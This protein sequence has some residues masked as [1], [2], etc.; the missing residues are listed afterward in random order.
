MPPKGQA[1]AQTK[2]GC[3][4]PWHPR[5]LNHKSSGGKRGTGPQDAFGETR[6]AGVRTNEA[7]LQA[8]VA[9]RFL[10][11]KSS[12]GKRGTGPKDACGKT[13][14]AGVPTLC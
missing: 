12:G 5:F 1:R 14:R 6:R 11:H 10:N 9:P 2:H 8:A 4:Q 3:K 7:R 13:R